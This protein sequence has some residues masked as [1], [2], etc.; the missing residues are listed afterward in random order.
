RIT[1][2]R[3]GKIHKNRSPTCWNAESDRV[4]GQDGLSSPKR[5]NGTN[6]GIRN[7]HKPE[8]IARNDLIEIGDKGT[9]M[10]AVRNTHSHHWPI[11]NMVKCMADGFLHDPCAW[12]TIGSPMK[13][14][15]M[16]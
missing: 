14:S 2:D 10:R 6:C 13:R 11:L 8:Q 5:R 7:R 3:S 12:K 9:N 16:I 1:C 4:R 15:T